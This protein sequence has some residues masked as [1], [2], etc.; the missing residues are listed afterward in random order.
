MS[1]VQ[2]GQQRGRRHSNVARVLGYAIPLVL[3]TASAAALVWLNQGPW[4]AW[5]LVT[6]LVVG[7]VALVR[8]WR[9]RAVLLRVVAWVVGAALV[10]GAA[11]LAHPPLQVRPA[12]GSDPVPTAAVDTAQGP[13]QGVS[14]DAR[15][16]EI[17]AGVPYAAPPVGELRWQPPQPAPSRPE[18]LVA[19]RFSAVP[20]QSTSTFASR[21]LAQ[22]VDVPL[23]ETFLNPYPVSEDS[24]TLNLWRST[25]PASE[26][27]P[28]LVYVPGGGFAT[29]SG[30]LPLYDGE[31]LASRGDVLTVTISYRL[32]V[33]GFLSH[34][35]LT[36]ESEHGASGNYGILDQL[37]ALAWVRDNIGAFG[38]D[39]DRVTVVGES[40]GG[41][42]VCVLGATPLAEGLIDGIIGGSGA[43]MGTTGDTSEGDQGDTREVAEAAGRRLSE[44]LGGATLAE[45]REMPV[46][47]VVEAAAAVGPHWRPSVDG[48]VLDRPPSEIYASGDQLDVPLLV[49]SNADEAS[50]ALAAPPEVDV[51]EYEHTVRETHGADA[52]VFLELYPG[53]TE[54]QVLD[55]LLQAQTDSVMTRAMYRWA[56]LHTRTATAPA[57]L[58]FFTH[59]PPD[60]GL[61]RFGAYHGAEIMYAFDNLGAD[62]DADY[63]PADLRLRDEVSG[64]WVDFVIDGDPNGGGR[65]PWSTVEESPDHVMEL[66]ATTAM[67]PRPRPEAID[68]WMAYSGP[69]P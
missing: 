46:E 60:A 6:A 21:A 9:R 39:P 3:V 33:L 18:V 29:G 49:G 57:Y 42:S 61:E 55:S 19:D 41:E 22:L 30:A 2:Q 40:A 48:Y 69:I 50:L 28:V 44:E 53:E 43:C 24:L 45:M 62:G 59:V 67:V 64:Y 23:E 7:L 52:D 47:E 4:W 14:N 68:Y 27:L 10:A 12:G 11:V 13:V 16:V 37:A 25:E 35:E 63:G 32:G 31:A 58:Y 54:E 26:A 56:L 20:V 65:P 17:F 1:S 5:L 36:A 34:P 8:A 51:V 38:G 15:T 66:G